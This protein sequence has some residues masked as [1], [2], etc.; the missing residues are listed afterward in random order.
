MSSLTV[1]EQGTRSTSN[2]CHP[3][4]HVG[5]SKVG[6][7]SIWWMV[8]IYFVIAK[9]SHYA[10]TT[11]TLCGISST[12]AC[13]FLVHWTHPHYDTMLNFH[14]AKC[15][16]NI[17]W[18]LSSTFKTTDHEFHRWVNDVV[19]CTGTRQKFQVDLFEG[20][21]L[22]LLFHAASSLPVK[23]IAWINGLLVYELW[24]F[25]LVSSQWLWLYLFMKLTSLNGLTVNNTGSSFLHQAAKYTVTQLNLN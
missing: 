2:L 25:W 22:P 17:L 15:P 8:N 21:L 14:C 19:I 16:L 11:G 12:G 24:R 9:Y 6:D 23:V 13:I 20:H 10:W 7:D 3:L 18:A 4:R 5:A 1:L